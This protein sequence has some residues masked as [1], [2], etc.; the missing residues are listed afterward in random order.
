MTQPEDEGARQT[1][2]LLGPD[3]ANWVPDHPGI[4][5]NVAI[6]GG[7]QTGCACAFALRRAGIGAV[8]LLEAAPNEQR[9]GIWLNAARMQLLRTPKSLTGPELTL[10]ALSFQ[11]WYE[12]RHGQDAYAA[13]DRIQRL[14]WAEYLSWYKSFLRIEPRYQTRVTRI[15]PLDTHFRLHLETSAGTVTETARKI[16][17]ATGF[18]GGG[19]KFIPDVLTANLPPDLYAHTEDAI[20][21]TALRG[22]T[23]GVIGA[24]AAA[25]DAAGVALE[26]GAAA[27]HLFARRDT[28]A[29]TPITRSRGFP[30]AYDNY[31]LLPDADRWH[32][33]IR[34]FRFGSTPT[35][36]AIERTVKHPHFHLHL[37]APWTSA[38]TVG[39]KMGGKAG[40]KVE[41]TINGEKYQ[42][43]FVIAGTG[44]SPDIAARPELRDFAG[45]ILLWRDRHTPPPEERDDPIALHPYLG[46][47]HE[48]LEKTPGT[49]PM[50]KH[51]HVQNPSGFL[52]FGLPIGDVPSMKRDIPVI[53]SR[54]SADL[55]TADLEALRARMTSDV[56]PDFTDEL[57]RAAV[58]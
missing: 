46:A 54:I 15:E 41:T 19:G 14:D 23:V 29:A 38:A 42:L 58:R 11:A 4:D 37:S 1:M 9:A 16:I 17:L 25:F 32:Q 34:F 45:Q 57:Y 7:G 36:D 56:K 6:I 39:G 10:P 51:I 27:V 13:I 5:H 47:G 20:D 49:A 28:I 50:L 3:P 48:F 52:S 53:V 2:R 55:F 40:G 26:N 44:Y 30:G 43:D 35:T 22:K 33:A 31:Y 21:F 12:A 24:A 8:T 18:A